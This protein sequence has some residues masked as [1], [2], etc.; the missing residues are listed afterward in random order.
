MKKKI[1][2]LF[3]ILLIS[4]SFILGFTLGNSFSEIDGETNK[5]I[6]ESELNAESFLIEQQLTEILGADC[7]FSQK[8]LS[9]LSEQLWHLGKILEKE[10][11]KK[12]IGKER[13]NYL[14]KK[15]H[16]MQIK[17]YTLCKSIEENC[18]KKSDIILFYFKRNDEKSK[19]QGIILDK[20]VEEFKTK[21]FAI[22]FDYA[23]EIKFLEDFYKINNAPALVINFNTI[24]IGLIEFDEIKKI[25]ENGS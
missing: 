6:R 15:F 14:K 1:N 9:K 11:S 4:F 19:K 18:G 17:T 12:E 20:I 8:R 2:F 16:L 13:Y 7:E 3:I 22:E 21:V 10:D 5:L 25:L 23:N 24:K